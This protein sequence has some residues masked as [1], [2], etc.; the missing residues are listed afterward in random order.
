MKEK[1][2]KAI[3]DLA[4]YLRGKSP[5]GSEELIGHQFYHYT[6][7]RSFKELTSRESAWMS[8]MNLV[9]DATYGPGWYVTTLPPD[10]ATSVLLQE[11]WGGNLSYLHKSEYWLLINV[12]EDYRTFRLPDPSRPHVVFLP[13]YNRGM[14]GDE[15]KPTGFYAKP[16]LLLKGGRRVEGGDGRVKVKTLFVPKSNFVLLPAH[17]NIEQGLTPLQRSIFKIHGPEDHQGGQEF[18]EEMVN[19][20]DALFS[21]GRLESA[22]DV[23][24]K[25]LTIVP[26]SVL[27]WSNKGAILAGLGRRHEAINC[28][29][30]ALELD[31][32]HVQALINKAASLIKLGRY[33]DA[34]E[35]CESAISIDGNSASAWHNKGNV[36]IELKKADEALGCFERATHLNP[37]LAEAWNSRA[38]LVYKRALN[39]IQHEPQSGEGLAELAEGIGFFTRSI[40]LR[41]SYENAR[42]NLQKAVDVVLSMLPHTY[43]CEAALFRAASVDSGACEQLLERIFR[44][45]LPTLHP[46]YLAEVEKSQLNRCLK[47]GKRTAELLAEVTGKIVSHEVVDL[48]PA[49]DDPRFRLGLHF[50]NAALINAGLPSF[51]STAAIS[52]TNVV[53]EAGERLQ[54]A[55]TLNDAGILFRKGQ[56]WDQALLCYERALP[57]YAEARDRKFCAHTQYNRG[58]VHY[59]RN[60]PGDIEQAKT[61]FKTAANIYS[62]LGL[63]EDLTE[64]QKRLAEL[65]TTKHSRR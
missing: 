7:K 29:D 32:K 10:T 47:Q 21:A 39:K 30:R 63:I 60:D 55:R 40:E 34:I 62:K 9:S 61:A 48:R 33:D 17:I 65:E 15:P 57:I 19:Q 27:G 46:K 25:L 23:V 36:L 58:I 49:M 31:P 2:R 52:L 44:D 51:A 56:A 8:S 45:Y 20:S 22:L 54:L 38:G 41:P 53:T 16:I 24:N 59:F 4:G 1:L 5:T 3:N 50:V 14:T 64:T 37:E 18:E 35:C 26:E 6:S 42:S 13:R 43:A 28:Y 12:L 11:L